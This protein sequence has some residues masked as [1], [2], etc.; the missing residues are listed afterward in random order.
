MKILF[1]SRQPPIPL[2]NGARMRTHAL[3][4]ELAASSRLH[5]LGW[6]TQPGNTLARESHEA[7]AAALPGAEAVELIPR[8]GREKRRLQLETMLLGRS[9]GF[10]THAH[11]P[12]ARALLRAIEEFEPDLLHCD[13]LLLGD[14]ARLAPPSIVRVMAL[15]NIESLLMARMADTTDELFRRKLY[16]KEAELRRQWEKAH[17]TE[18][19][20]CTCV[21]NEDANHVAALGANAVCVP[22][23]VDRHQKPSPVRSLGDSEPLKLLF[24]GSGSWEPNRMGMAWFVEKV[25]PAIDCPVFP[26]ITIV[27]AHWDWLDSPYC[28][29]AGHVPSIEEYYKSHDV[30]LVPLLA[31]GGSRL[32]VAE[33]LAKGVPLV[34]TSVGLEGYS[35]VPGVHA[36]FGDTPAQLAGQ[37]QDLDKNYRT[38]TETVDRQV[39]AG[40]QHIERFFWDEIGRRMIGVYE[41]VVEEKRS[42]RP[43]GRPRPV[44]L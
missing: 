18:F 42:G 23:G 21:F 13:D 33:A 15:H 38:A 35:L 22:N 19:D 6:D 29:V 14:L 32:K 43:S 30:A 26:Q 17:L 3:A 5:F 8:P 20:L 28:Q 7:V 37:I 44:Q 39:A 40:F 25:L 10:R 31:G 24:I 9:Y 12:M 11:K 36:L 1:F 4:N 2:D 34:G 16:I 41:D 27:G